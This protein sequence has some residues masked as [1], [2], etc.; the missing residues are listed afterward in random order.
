MTEVTYSGLEFLSTP[1][2]VLDGDFRV[3]YLNPSAE[4]L[5]ELNLKNCAGLKLTQ[6]LPGTESLA[7]MSRLALEQQSAYMEHEL[8]LT[9]P[10]AKQ[11][12]HLSCTLTPVP[13]MARAA[14]LL[15]FVPLNQQIKI[16]REERILHEQQLNRELIRSLAHEIRNPLGGIRGAA[17]LLERELDRKDQREYTQVIVKEADRLQNLMDRLL[18]PRRQ[19]VLAEVDIHEVLERVRSLILAEYPSGI[20]IRRDYDLSLPELTGDREQ[21]I[22]AVL[23]IV[24]NAVQALDGKGVVELRTRIA[25]QITLARRR[26]RLG[27][28]VEIVDNGPGIPPELADKVFLPLVSG[29]EGGSGVGLTIAQTFIN[30]HRGIIEFESEPGNTCF[31]LL[32]PIRRSEYSR[33]RE[34][35]ETT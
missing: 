5:F 20:K 2:V 26:F 35:S 12:L 10:H 29:R 9:G 27:I 31:K 14:M 6:A 34:R 16:A 13:E 15:E 19:Q 24:R 33:P 4:S 17:Q 28:T 25:R 3:R 8:I 21:L 22:Q 30:Q 18:A 23:N 32:L 11:A 1:V 7:S